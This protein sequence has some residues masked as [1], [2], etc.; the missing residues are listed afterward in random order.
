MSEGVP[1]FTNRRKQKNYSALPFV[2]LLIYKILYWCSHLKKKIYLMSSQFFFF[3][4]HSTN[5]WYL[6][7]CIISQIH[8]IQ[9]FFF[10]SVL[11]NTNYFLP[12]QRPVGQ[13][14]SP[15]YALSHSGL[16][17]LAI[18]FVFFCV[19]WDLTSFFQNIL[20]PEQ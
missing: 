15:H 9:L 2:C 19:S 17:F 8:Q 18:D 4:V 3:P 7:L 1:Q 11:S 12:F 14:F 13:L 10:M 5:W 16:Y 6:D 20:A